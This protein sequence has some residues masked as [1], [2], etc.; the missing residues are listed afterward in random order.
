LTADCMF[1]VLG[2]YVDYIMESAKADI[3][4]LFKIN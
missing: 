2:L 1:K 3:F 4:I